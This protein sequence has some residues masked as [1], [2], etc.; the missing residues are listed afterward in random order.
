VRATT[1]AGVQERAQALVV[2]AVPLTEDRIRLIEKQR[3][4]V[5]VDLAED[6]RLRGGDHLPRIGDEQLEHL[7]Q[8]RLAGALLGRGDGKIRTCVR[9]LEGVRVHDPERDRGCLRRRHDDEPA[10]EDRDLVKG[11]DDWRIAGAHVPI[12][13]SFRSRR[14]R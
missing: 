8:A 7:E 13:R 4:A 5:G 2:L 1:V 14:G 3:R 10:D 6:H 12:C 11:I 9:G